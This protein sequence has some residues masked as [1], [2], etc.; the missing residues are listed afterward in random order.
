MFIFQLNIQYL[1]LL[2]LIHKYLDLLIKQ[3][4][5]FVTKNVKTYAI[6]RQIWLHM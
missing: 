3:E 2:I 1:I 5:I 4:C 6:E